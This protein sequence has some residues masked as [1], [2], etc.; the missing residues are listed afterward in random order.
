MATDWQK[1]QPRAGDQTTEVKFKFYD[2]IQRIDEYNVSYIQYGSEASEE[3]DKPTEQ[4]VFE[5]DGLYNSKASSITHS[6]T[7]F[8]PLMGTSLRLNITDPDQKERTVTINIPPIP[9]EYLHC[10]DP[11]QSTDL[12]NIQT[13][14]YTFGS[15]A[16]A[17]GINLKL[18][19]S[20]GQ[21]VALNPSS[22]RRSDA[23][24]IGLPIIVNTKVSQ[25]GEFKAMVCEKDQ[26][27][28]EASSL[29]I[30][31]HGDGYL[32]I[33]THHLS[34]FGVEEV[35]KASESSGGDEGN[36]FIEMLWSK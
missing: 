14:Y 4:K 18:Y 5:V 1:D 32:E 7:E 22:G 36:C 3:A 20:N 23:P 26:T 12:L 30:V 24:V 17:T 25:S 19:N 21:Y 28:F 8:Y 27:Q 2:G 13:S 35:I 15:D 16:L 34:G 6:Q 9:L 29:A 33:Q 11:I 31:N 10:E